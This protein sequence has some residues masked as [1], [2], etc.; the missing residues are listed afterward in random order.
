MDAFR[1]DHQLGLM[2]LDPCL[3]FPS[4]VGY[5]YAGI[6]YFLFAQ[7]FMLSLF[8]VQ[9]SLHKL[10][11]EA[12][13]VAQRSLAQRWPPGAPLP[14]QPR[15]GALLEVLA[16]FEPISPEQ[17]EAFGRLRRAGENRAVSM[18][19]TCVP[20]DESLTLLAAGF[21]SGEPGNPAI[22]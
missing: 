2:F 18:T 9:A 22:P 19:G 15:D 12:F 16:E 13:A 8:S 3:G 20:V 1:G 21:S 10:L 6:A 7:R 17:R 14:A 5:F 4:G 11:K